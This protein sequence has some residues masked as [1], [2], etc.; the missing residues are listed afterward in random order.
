MV[1]TFVAGLIRWK[2]NGRLPARA[3]FPLLYFLPLIALTLS[4]R[5]YF[6]NM[7][8]PQAIVLGAFF[9]HF[10]KCVLECL[11]LHKYSGDSKFFGSALISGL[12]SAGAYW[13]GALNQ[14]P[15]PLTF[16]WSAA[17]IILF[18]IGI[19]GNFYYHKRLAGF[20]EQNMEYV[21]PNGGLF[22]WIICP[23]YLFEFIGW[24]GIFLLSRHFAALLVVIAML[25]YLV[26]RSRIT[27]NWYRKTFRDFP[28][29]R[30]AL[31]PFL[32]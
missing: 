25:G 10:V 16:A 31:I 23:H 5:P 27:L 21:I 17:G 30:K 29:G 20:R 9:I 3:G 22:Q 15:L 4:A 11:F 19:S 8:A 28:P 32:L 18:L 13:I 7:T 26:V 14:T 1:Y 12:Y 24:F 2:Y 6:A